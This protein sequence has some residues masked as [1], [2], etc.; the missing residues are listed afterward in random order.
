LNYY[1]G[2]YNV[3]NGGIIMSKRVELKCKIVNPEIETLEKALNNLFKFYDGDMQRNNDQS[4]SMIIEKMGIYGTK[5]KIKDGQIVVEGYDDDNEAM[6]VQQAVENFYAAT[7]FEE[8]FNVP[9]E[10]DEEGDI[11][12]NVEV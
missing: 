9:I 8:E 3:G 7:L 4:I 6:N 1:G 11:I 12:L 10:M 5:I 2:N